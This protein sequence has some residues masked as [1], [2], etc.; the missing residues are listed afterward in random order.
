MD[1][2]TKKRIKRYLSWACMAGIVVLLT[3]MPLMAKNEA[4]KDG[5]QASVLSATVETGSITSVLHGGGTLEDEDVEDV[6]IPTGVKITGFLVKNGDMVKE[7]DPVAMVDK[8]SVM[9]AITSVNETLDFLREK[10][11]DGRDEKVDSTITAV[12]GGRVKKIFAKEGESVQDVMLR[13]GALAVLSID[14]MMAVRF[15]TAS[16][17]ATGENMDVTLENGTTVTG[18]VESNLDGV[19]VVTVEDEGYEIGQTVTAEG[20]GTGTLYIHN[21]WKATG[22]TGTISKVHT[23]EEKNLSAG[24]T[25]FTLDDREFEG[26]LQHRANQHREYEALLQTLLKLYESGTIDAPCEG[27]VSGVDQDSVHLLSG[28]GEWEVQLLSGSGE[29]Q[30]RIVL[31][32]GGTTCSHAT[33]EGVCHAST[34]ENDCIE[35]CDPNNCPETVTVH[36]KTCI[37]RCDPD[38]PLCDSDVHK[39]GC[40]TQCNPSMEE[41][42]PNAQISGSYHKTDCI[43]RCNP[44]AK[45]E[46]ECPGTLHHYSTC[47]KSCISCDEGT[48]C[49]ATGTHKKTCVERC[50]HAST[51]STCDSQKHYKDCIE[52]CTNNEACTAT[53]HLT[54]CHYYGV[55]YTATAYKVFRVGTSELVVFK[56]PSGTTYPV[57]QTAS[58]WKPVGCEVNTSILVQTGTIP[59]TNASSFKEGDIVLIITGTRPDGTV[60]TPNPNVVLYSRTASTPGFDMSGM[61]NGMDLS[62]LMGGMDLSGMVGGFSGYGNFGGL[63]VPETESLHNL[64]GSTLLTVTPRKSMKLTITLDEQD[65]SKVSVGMSATVK[66]EALKNQQF[67]GLVTEVGTRGTNSGGSSKFTAEITLTVEGDMLSGMS[68]SASIPMETKENIL[69]IPVAALQELDGKTVV[70]T[71]LE[72]DNGE[73]NTAVE[74]VTGVSDGEYVEILSGLSQGDTVYYTYY[75]TLE[76]DTSAEAERFTFG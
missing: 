27:V 44:N 35:A 18:R 61:M 64:E 29:P 13:D 74:V 5:P 75:D 25:L 59:A 71:G 76:E 6:I 7:G 23:E 42:C 1:K 22:Y 39:T 68:A 11:E 52:S 49:P 66:V 57:E 70:Y 48:D 8:T 15:E 50:I 51:K 4:Q 32:S 62:G 58:G 56:D 40:I 24:A 60:V 72:K 43:Y 54:T 3:V 28:E 55:T 41:A 36:K 17:L 46:S 63:T 38:N 19:V 12:P 34:H 26:Q 10:L 73:P 45:E 9:E 37:K 16:T 2:T 53:K 20:L 14:S 69:I 67:S 65:I 47:I 21:A 31:L 33:E 30:Y